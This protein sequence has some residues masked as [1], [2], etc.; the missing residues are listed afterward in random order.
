ML[1]RLLVLLLLCGF[2]PV[3]HADGVLVLVDSLASSATGG[4]GGAVATAKNIAPFMDLLARSLKPR[5]KLTVSNTGGTS[6]QATWSAAE[7]QDSISTSGNSPKYDY[8]L[9][10]CIEAT[11]NS[12]VF[13][14]NNRAIPRLTLT[15]NRPKVPVLYLSSIGMMHNYVADDTLGAVGVPISTVDSMLVTSPAG[16]AFPMKTSGFVKRSTGTSGTYVTPVLWF[17]GGG[18]SK[19]VPTGYSGNSSGAAD[20]MVAW[21]YNPPK[22]ASGARAGVGSDNGFGYMT[23]E[24]GTSNSGTANYS[25][26]MDA[27]I[28]VGMAARLAPTLFN[29]PGSRI[30][31]DVDDGCKRFSTASSYPQIEDALAGLDSLGVWGIPYTL[32]VEI[33]SLGTQDDNG[34]SRFQN[35]FPRIRRYGMGKV[36]VHCHKGL[37]AGGAVADT[38]LASAAS[39]IYTD[40]FGVAANRMAFGST[41][42]TTRDQSTFMQL[43]GATKKLIDYAGDQSFVT[44]HVMPPTDNYKSVRANLTDPASGLR[45]QTY[46]STSY[47]IALAGAGYKGFPGYRIVRTQYQ[48]NTYN[49]NVPGNTGGFARGTS[50]PLPSIVTVAAQMTPVVNPGVTRLLYVTSAYLWGST[51]DTA[52]TQ[53]YGALRTAT[54]QIL[55]TNMGFNRNYDMTTA[56][57]A[58]GGT[59]TPAARGTARALIM[60]TH[61]PNW[62]QGIGVT[63]IVYGGGRPAWEQTRAV[64]GAMEAAKWC[65]LQAN[66]STTTY[67]RDGPVKWIYSDEFTDK[68][69]R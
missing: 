66:T 44:R 27:V 2:A 6:T 22:A 40:I 50:Y 21:F 48:A 62:R 9:I 29:F 14:T 37:T 39:G 7:L 67:F 58:S 55:G 63:G 25:S 20:S 5:M 1:K 56:G 23:L 41:S 69:L 11:D 61:L 49:I 65:A 28:A 4:S 38:S 16:F 12:Y 45:Y 53:N 3:A 34:N 35:E 57:E 42:G 8:S 59:S 64:N 18:Y 68:D 46:D 51:T 17:A 54:N 19:T 15:G 52:S 31:L 36:T 60:V 32:G 10:I 47:A 33:D 24:P 30:A 13:N 43:N 26:G